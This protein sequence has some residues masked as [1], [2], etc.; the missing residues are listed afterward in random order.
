[1]FRK[2]FFFIAIFGFVFTSNSQMVTLKGNVKDSLQNPLAFANV[3]AKP[4]DISKN[5]QFAITD[6]EGMYRLSLTKDDVYTISISYLGYNPVDYPFIATKTTTKN[7]IL[8]ETKNQLEEV[9][10]EMPVVVKQETTIYNTKYFTDGTER[11]LKNVLKKLPGVEVDKNGGVTVQGKKV[12]RMLVDGKKFFNGGTKLAVDNIP[13]DAIDKVEVLENYNEVTFLKNISDSDEMAMNIKL[14]KNKK[15]F[16]FGDVE[17]GKGNEHYYRTHANLFYYSPKTNVNFIGNLNNTGEKTFTFKDYMNFQGGINAVFDG[18][19]KWGNDDFSQFLN[20]ND[21]L[22]S[23]NKFAALHI[24]KTASSKLDISGFAIISKT[25]THSFEESSNQYANITEQKENTTNAENIFG[26]G[27][28]N[29]EY[30]PNNKTQWYARTQIKKTN[31][32][33]KNEIFSEINTVQN[34]INTNK[35]TAAISVNQNIEW[36]KRQSIKHT[37]SFIADYTFDK[38]NP[39]NYWQTSNKILQGLIPLDENQQL[40]RLHQNREISQQNFNTIFKHFWVLNNFNHIYTTV[41]NNLS[42]EN[43][44]TLDTQEL[45]N[46]TFND[47][48]TSGFGNDVHF[49]FNDFFAGIHYKFKTGITTF[50][51]GVMLHKYRWNVNQQSTFS[52]SKWVALPDFLATI[53]FNK[54]KKI[55]LRYHLKTNFSSASTL[56]NR[57]YLQ[58]YNS[59]FKGNESLENE[60]YHNVNI[61]YN[62]FSLF[63]GLRLYARANY[64]KKVKGFTNVVVLDE[65]NPDQTQRANRYITIQLFQNPSEN[66]TMNGHV[67][68][69]IKKTKYKL[70][71]SVNLSKYVQNINNQIQ[72]NKNNSYTTDVGIETL[73]DNFPTIE[74]GYK[75]TIGNYTSGNSITKFIRSEP[76]LNIDYSFLKG[77]IFNFDYTRSNYQNKSLGQKNVYELANT[78][79]SYKNDDSAW[80]YKITVNN[81]FNTTFKQ[82]NS[83][84]DYLITDTKT[85]ILPRV[86]MFSI[87]YNL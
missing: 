82:S 59:V 2:S 48:S 4:K 29:L 33:N 41:G 6:E 37:F 26:I 27:K 50:K 81:V 86:L 58:S 53:E 52:K 77:F 38:N 65:T 3:I 76:Y 55:E 71:G 23:E 22:K 66:I 14:K 44:S 85:F 57:Y 9:V 25:N 64:S 67:E 87:A 78:T 61:Y 1:M 19:F 7:F 70:G 40:F 80:S 35:K 75:R 73:F 5:L 74:I 17:A 24:T 79:L 68:K 11:K 42:N 47:F 72:T 39:I 69:T 10:I 28:L 16:L 20:S 62:R 56:V 8:K 36:H 49:K 30:A 51:Q 12:T 32:T 83:F 60:L 21:I 31:N 15:N 13:A 18:T 45:D 46:V 43:F 84:S 34:I 54:S 63:R